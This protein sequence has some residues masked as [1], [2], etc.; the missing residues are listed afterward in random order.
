[1]SDFRGKAAARLGLAMAAASLAV[2]ALVLWHLSRPRPPA[3]EAASAATT[4]APA[5]I[6]FA[7]ARFARPRVVPPLS[8]AAADGRKLTLADFRGK[9][10]LLNLWATWCAPC[11]KE[12]PTLDRLQRRLGGPRFAVVALSIDRLGLGAV[13]PFYKKLGLEALG[14]YL[15]PSGKAAGALDLPG[16]PTS[17]LIDGEGRE[18]ARKVG[19]AEWDQPAMVDKIEQY[20]KAPP[21]NRAAG[22]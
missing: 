22:N 20:L 19:P 16:L 2:L 15:D 4:A 1:M 8:F 9:A 14:I 10:V 6:D 12:M 3:G 5:G 17:L 13:A 21:D 7:F 18:I 11:R